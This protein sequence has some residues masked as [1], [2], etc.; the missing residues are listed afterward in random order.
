MRSK[1]RVFY[2]WLI[3]FIAFFDMFVIAGA[4][5][6]FGQ[7]IGPLSQAFGWSVGVI[8]LASTVRQLTSMG[9]ALLVGRLT[10]TAG[11][12]KIMSAGALLAGCAYCL[13]TVA[14]DP[15]IFFF[16]FS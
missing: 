12:R 16:L 10:D 3:V 6:T 14:R 7:F 8:G 11:P 5:V 15:A 1:H 4:F 13:L 9:A 2:G